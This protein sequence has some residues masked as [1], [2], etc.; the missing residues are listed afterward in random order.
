MAQTSLG[1]IPRN[2]P[3]LL[4]ASM[5]LRWRSRNAPQTISSA[6]CAQY[7]LANAVARTLTLCRSTVF[8]GTSGT[9]D[10]RQLFDLRADCPSSAAW[11]KLERDSLRVTAAELVW[12]SQ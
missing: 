2:P 11:M 10:L 8:S 6:A 7:R 9:V 1:R 5:G 3:A 4:A 12:L